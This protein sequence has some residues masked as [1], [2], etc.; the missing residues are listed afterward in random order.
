LIYL[1]V[2]SYLAGALS[3]L[4]PCV[5]PLLPIILGGSFN[6]TYNDKRR[7]YIIIASLTL[8]LFSFTLLLKFSTSLIGIDPQV[9][10][11]ISGS[12]LIILGIFMLFPSW[13]AFIIGRLGLEHKSQGFL[14]QANSKHKGVASAILTGLALGPVFSSCSPTYAWV[15]ASVLP[16]SFIKGIIYLLFYLLGL[17]SVLLAVALLGRSFISKIKWATNPKGWFNR[18]IAILFI[19][20]GLF[21]MTGLDKKLQTYL[22]EQDYFNIKT[23]ELQLSPL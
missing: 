15:I 4:A 12:I 11:Y 16:E 6:T 3:A 7:P 5:L 8:S 13:W 10:A 20:V 17:A 19:L 23:I 2:I 22:V 18:I 9:W 21:V 1:I 14:G